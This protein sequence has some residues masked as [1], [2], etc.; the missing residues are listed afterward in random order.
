MTLKHIS[1]GSEHYSM[2]L[3][4]LAK[5]MCRSRRRLCEPSTEGRGCIRC[6]PYARLFPLLL[7]LVLSPRPSGSPAHPHAHGERGAARAHL[8]PL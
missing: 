8:G 7:H 6:S 3:T 1:R 2:Y 5:E 4:Y